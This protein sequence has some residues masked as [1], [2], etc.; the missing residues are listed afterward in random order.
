[1]RFL[2]GSLFVRIYL[3]FLAGLVGI[4]LAGGLIFM[5]SQHGEGRVEW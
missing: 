2:R 3:T 1:M 4:V 5:A